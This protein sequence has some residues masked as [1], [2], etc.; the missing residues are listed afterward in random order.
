MRIWSFFSSTRNSVKFL[1][2]NSLHGLQPE[3]IVIASPL[4]ARSQGASWEKGAFEHPTAMSPHCPH[5]IQPLW[6]YFSS[7][8]RLLSVS[9][10]EWVSFSVWN[11]LHCRS[12]FPHSVIPTYSSLLNLNIIFSERIPDWTKLALCPSMILFL[13]FLT[14]LPSC[15]GSSMCIVYEWSFFPRYEDVLHKGRGHIYFVTAAAMD[16]AQGT[17]AKCPHLEDGWM[18]G[19]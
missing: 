17:K 16:S 5:Q 19:H 4:W 1:T 2:H 14:L 12:H 3:R 11:A 9:T 18:M 6:A 13:S 15:H 7:S 10:L 8:P